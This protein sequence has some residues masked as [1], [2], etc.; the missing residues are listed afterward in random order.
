MTLILNR[1]QYSE[2]F[3]DSWNNGTTMVQVTGGSF[4]AKVRA[5]WPGLTIIQSQWTT[6]ATGLLY[7]FNEQVVRRVVSITPRIIDWDENPMEIIM[8]ALGKDVLVVPTPS[9]LIAA[10]GI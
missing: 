8:A 1:T 2:L 4:M 7:P 6:A 10:T 5:A 9:A 3:R